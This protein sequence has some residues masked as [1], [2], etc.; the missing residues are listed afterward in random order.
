MGTTQPLHEQGLMAVVGVGR[1]APVIVVDSRLL[2][3]I[4]FI[5]KKKKR[6]KKKKTY[7]PGDIVDVS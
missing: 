4:I 2:A 6:N 5:S 7:S 3:R 1:G